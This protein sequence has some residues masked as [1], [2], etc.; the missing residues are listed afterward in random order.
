MP[1]KKNTA[2]K[3]TGGTAT[4]VDFKAAA[5]STNVNMDVDSDA[6]ER[7]ITT[8]GSGASM[9]TAGIAAGSETCAN[10]DEMI[11]GKPLIVEDHDAGLFRSTIEP[12]VPLFDTPLRLD[13]T[14][15]ANS[16]SRVCT[17]PTIIFNFRLASIA[18]TETV[19]LTVFNHLESYY[20]SKI[21]LGYQDVKFAFKDL[22]D[23]KKYQEKLEK[24]ISKLQG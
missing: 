22:D 19:G 17:M 21:R 4:R 5:R 23:V 6:E 10:A 8:D 20:R 15:Q 11:L 2:R 12:N 16:V 24:T 3:T 1:A 13:S 14:F 18:E 9:N 7:V